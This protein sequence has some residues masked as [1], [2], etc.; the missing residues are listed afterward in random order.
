MRATKYGAFCVNLRILLAHIRSERAQVRGQRIGIDI[1]LFE[2]SSLV[3]GVVL[4]SFRYGV[5]SRD[6]SRGRVDR[7]YLR[8]LSVTERR[9]FSSSRGSFESKA[10]G[11]G[12]FGVCCTAFVEGSAFS[13]QCV[14]VGRFQRISQPFHSQ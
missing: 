1:G 13:I 12:R 9:V 14:K 11:L 2:A 8:G 7:C 3:F 10:S 5:V 4:R 6:A